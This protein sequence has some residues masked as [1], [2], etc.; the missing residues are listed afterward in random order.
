MQPSGQLHLLRRRLAEC[1]GQYHN[2]DELVV[3]LSTGWYD[4]GNR[5]LDFINIRGNGRRVR[6]KV[7]DECVLG[8]QIQSQPKL[9]RSRRQLLL[10]VASRW[11]GSH[12]LLVKTGCDIYVNN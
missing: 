3:A 10:F 12:K 5:C 2:D 4:N 8:S 7:V 1:D 9:L 6:A 11:T